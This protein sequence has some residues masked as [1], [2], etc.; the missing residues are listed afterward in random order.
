MSKESLKSKITKNAL[1][2]ILI[3]ALPVVVVY[4]YYFTH[5]GEISSRPDPLPSYL[6]FFSPFAE[7]FKNWGL[8]AFMLVLGIFEFALGLYG[9]RW[10]KNEKVLDIVCFVI[11]KILV[12]PVITYFSLQILPI[13]LPSGSG[14]LSWIPF[15]YGFLIMSVADDLT[16]YWYHRLHHQIPFLWRFHRTHHSASYMAWPWLAGRM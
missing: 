5:R 16:Q 13:L 9:K 2:S 3:Y 7:N 4:L 12:T 6:S 11:P 10:T 15:W 14:V 8:P 1:L